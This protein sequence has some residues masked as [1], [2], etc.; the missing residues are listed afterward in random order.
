MQVLTVGAHLHAIVEIGASDSAS[1]DQKAAEVRVLVHIAPEEAGF[2]VHNFDERVVFNIFLPSNQVPGG[3]DLHQHL[4]V[5]KPT[6]FTQ[7]DPEPVF[8]IFSLASSSEVSFILDFVDASEVAVATED[9]VDGIHL[10]VL[11]DD[12]RAYLIHGAVEGTDDLPHETLIG[13]LVVDLVLEEV[14]HLL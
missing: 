5:S 7:L 6:A 8:T 2:N 1:Q 13:L 3:V 12:V 11:L 14:S 10:L 9:E 4:E